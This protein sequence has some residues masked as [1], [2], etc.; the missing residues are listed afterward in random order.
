L[1]EIFTFFT[2]DG[3]VS[4]AARLRAETFG[5]RSQK[6]YRYFSLL[7]MIHTGS[8]AKPSSYR[9]LSPRVKRC[10]RKTE[11]LLPYRGMVRNEWNYTTIP[12]ILLRGLCRYNVQLPLCHSYLRNACS[13][14]RHFQGNWFDSKDKNC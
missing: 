1:D 11:F 6:I 3:V 12:P 10:E 7:L 13:M 5:V 2:R 4:T 9:A 8:W 14:F